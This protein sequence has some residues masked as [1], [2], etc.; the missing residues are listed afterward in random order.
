LWI[1]DLSQADRLASFSFFPQELNLLPII[2]AVLQLLMMKISPQA[3]PTDP[4]Q[5]MQQ[6]MM[7]YMPL[8]FSVMLYRMA[9]GLMLYF[10]ASAVFGI[11]ES[12]YIRKFLIKDGHAPAPVLATATAKK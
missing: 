2:Y 12:W 11:I 10:A 3:K 4:Q 8:V 5:E 9:A 1:K 7:A 6:K